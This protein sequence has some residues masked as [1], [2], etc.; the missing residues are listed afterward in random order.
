METPRRA[1]QRAKESLRNN[2]IKLALNDDDE[3]KRKEFEKTLLEYERCLRSEQGEPNILLASKSA[4]R[5]A[6]KKFH[7]GNDDRRND[8]R[9]PE[10]EG[11][12]ESIGALHYSIENMTNSLIWRMKAHE[13]NTILG[14]QYLLQTEVCPNERCTPT[15]CSAIKNENQ[16]LK[17]KLEKQ[18]SI[19]KEIISIAAKFTELTVDCVR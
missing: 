13:K 10:R 19:I 1:S 7:D 16:V 6:K 15:S 11:S 14:V 8:I 17:D 3:T 5:S 2:L 4:S 12:H 9:Y 18:I